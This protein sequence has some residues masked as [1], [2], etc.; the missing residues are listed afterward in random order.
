MISPNLPIAKVRLATGALVAASALVSICSATIP[1]NG[2]VARYKLNGN[3]LDSG[4]SQNNGTMYGGVAPAPD[5]FGVAGAADAPW[6]SSLYPD[7]GYAPELANLETDKVLEDFSYAGYHAGADPIPDASGPVFNVTGAPYLADPTGQQDATAKIQAAIN[8]AGAAGGGVVFL[9]AGKYKLSI[10]AGAK[11]AL[12][13][14]QSHV[15]LRGAGIDRT[16]LINSTFSGVRSK[17]VVRV[18]GPSDASFRSSGSAQ[19]ALASDLLRST[20][21]VPVADVSPFAVGQTVVVRNSITDAWITEQGEPDWLGQGSALRGL[22]YRRTISAIDPAAK[23]LLLDAPIRYA[24]KLRDSARVHRLSAPLAESGL[25]DFSIGQIQ[26]PATSWNDADGDIPGTAGYDVTDFFFIQIERARDCWLRRIASFQPDG[27]T[28]TAHLLSSGV[29][30]EET[31]RVTI[32]DCVLQRPQYGGS[33]GNGYM[34]LLSNAAET[35]VQRCEARYTRHGFVITGIGSSGNVVYNCLDAQTGRATG[36]T[37]YMATGGSGS[38]QHKHFSQANLIDSCTADDSWFEARYRPFGSVPHHNITAVHSVFWNLRGIG[39]GPSY[40]VRSEQA[41]YGYVIG[42]SGTRFDVDLPRAAPPG[43]D[44]VDH[45]EGAGLGASLVPSS[46]YVDQRVRRLGPAVALP[47]DTVLPF[48]ANSIEIKPLG[49]TLGGLPVAASVLQITWNAAPGVTLRATANGGVLVRIPGPGE[50]ALECV[51]SYGALTR[52]QSMHIVAAA[53]GL[54]TTTRTLGAVGDTYVQ[55][56]TYA[57]TNFGAQT[58]LALKVGGAPVYIRRALLRFDLTALGTE[59]PLN[60]SLILHAKNLPV[61]HAQWSLA[62]RPILSNAWT[63]STVT[64]NNA[65][66]FGASLATY[67]PSADS[68]DEID[69][70]SSLLAAWQARSGVLDFGLTVE[71]QPDSSLM[72][73]CSREETNATLRPRLEIVAALDVFASWIGTYPG[74]PA[75]KR[76]PL[77]DPD[78]DQVTNVM[79]MLLKRD[80]S[81]ADGNSPLRWIDGALVFELSDSPPALKNFQLQHSSD[82]ATWTAVEV[83]PDQIG[84]SIGGSR[85]IEVPAAPTGPR[86]FWRLYIELEP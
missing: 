55:G 4:A 14:N 47:P 53:P 82:L 54:I 24:L 21:T 50:W 73:Y 64:W 60:G 23:T 68:I 8:A 5:R 59:R 30:L 56:D 74:V 63:E 44:P 58:T 45:V 66:A 79:E 83:T 26:N 57:A 72:Y 42:T 19:V 18:A 70:F 84:A 67:A 39:P 12:L 33:G 85:R 77:D 40:V 10:P 22:T 65:P 41:R 11:E 31:T 48:P 15:V 46:L 80:P 62:L 1:T 3:A 86:D 13:I 52:S 25:E 61:S 35:L 37:G 17:V 36:A 76:A 7:T 78:G 16:F 34:Y 38:D 32:E 81:R 43:T 2:L 71:S 69:V 49:F 20:R 51:S 75:D 27:N 29:A 28:S 6:R 9:P